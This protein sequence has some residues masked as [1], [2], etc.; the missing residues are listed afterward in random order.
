MNVFL[1]VFMGNESEP[2]SDDFV[3]PCSD[4]CSTFNIK[5]GVINFKS[6][7]NQTR[8][9]SS[10]KVGQISCAM[11]NTSTEVKCP[12]PTCGNFEFIMDLKFLA[13][14]NE[15]SMTPLLILKIEK[16]CPKVPKQGEAKRCGVMKVKP[17]RET[18]LLEN[19]NFGL[20]HRIRCY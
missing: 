11:I 8:S 7:P 19:L 17:K 16:G 10:S 18:N 12:L 6:I 9:T 14:F 20:C 1:S 5:R 4:S 3:V 2:F 13:G 15:R